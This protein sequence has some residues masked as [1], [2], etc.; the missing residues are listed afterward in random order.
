M[1][2]SYLAR[3][4]RRD[5]MRLL[6]MGSGT[7]AVGALTTHVPGA[8]GDVQRAGASSSAGGAIVRTLLKDVP[9][10]ALGN[11]AVLLHEHL[12]LGGPKPPEEA[13]RILEL[14]KKA[15]RE[16]VSCIVDVGMND[17]GRDVDS[18]KQIASQT[19]VHIV[20]GGGYSPAH[21]DL[22]TLHPD[23]LQKSEDQIADDLVRD[24]AARRQGVFG[25]IGTGSVSGDVAKAGGPITELERKVFRAT[26]K[27]HVRTGLPIITHTAYHRVP[28]APKNFGLAQL[29]ALESVGVNPEHVV[30]GHLCCTNDPGAEQAKAIA[31]R[32]AF[33]GFDRVTGVPLPDETKVQMVQALLAAGLGHKLILASDFIATRRN[34]ATPPPEGPGLERT[35]TVF[36]PLLRKAG[37][38]DATIR[39]LTVN[40]PRRV[41]AFV[42]KN[43]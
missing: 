11:G 33:V 2:I 1:K 20:A 29:D 42:P 23:I 24:A 19:N 27:A 8:A 36:V 25:E 40:N 39:D 30:I 34:L 13:N 37:I 12:S 26:G 7:T 31:K 3:L 43:G 28:D 10:D 21:A 38:A 32:G 14:V 16:G 18:L 5:A 17:L 22:P 6:L 35:V 4:S 41:L 9:A 15:G